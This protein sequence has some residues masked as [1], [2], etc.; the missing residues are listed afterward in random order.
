VAFHRTRTSAPGMESSEPSLRD[1]VQLARGLATS[2]AP[3]T[4]QRS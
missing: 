2:E 1:Y 3:I 4:E